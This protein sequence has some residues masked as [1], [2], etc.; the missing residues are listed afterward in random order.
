MIVDGA[1]C[2]HAAV[3]NI[4]PIILADIVMSFRHPA[5]IR[6]KFLQRRVKPFHENSFNVIAVAL[7]RTLAPTFAD[8]MCLP[9]SLPGLSERDPT[10][11]R[12]SFIA[13]R[14]GSARSAS[15]SGSGADWHGDRAGASGR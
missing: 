14:Y 8:K 9:V 12:C 1:K 11:S 10:R 6:P 7:D 3:C 4:R 13:R 5:G 2:S 15:R